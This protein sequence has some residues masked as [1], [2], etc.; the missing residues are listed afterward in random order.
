MISNFDLTSDQVKRAVETV[1][2]SKSVYTDMLGFYGRLFIAQEESK[3]RVR[4]EPLNI[5]EDMLAVKTREKLPLI[6][7]KDFAYDKIEGAKLFVTIGK[8]AADANPKMAASAAVILDAV[9]AELNPERLLSAL[10][11]GNEVLFEN[12]AEELEIDKQILGFITYNSLKPSLSLCADQLATYLSKDEPWLKGYCPICGSPPILS[13]L[14]EEGARRLICSFCWHEWA[15]KRVFCPFCE[16]RD[17][18]T[19]QYFYSDEEIEFR[20]DVCDN[21]KK[22]LKT[23]DA[24]KADR[25]IYPPLEQIS[26]LHLDLKAK[27][28]GFE[29]GIRLFMPI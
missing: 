7:I 20:V 22:Y 26:T 1:T 23:L 17:N 25:L 13:I 6:E 18:T 5:P 8:L 21:C 15:A 19:Q 24:R 11:S 3:R 28:M 16:N 29:S 9:A 27:E 14:G 2:K 12:I 10:L 4:V